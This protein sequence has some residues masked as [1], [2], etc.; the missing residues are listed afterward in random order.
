MNKIASSI[1]VWAVYFK[2]RSGLWIKILKDFKV[3]KYW[4]TLRFICIIVIFFWG[5]G[6]VTEKQLLFIIMNVWGYFNN[7]FFVFFF[8]WP[9][10][11]LRPTQSSSLGAFLNEIRKFK[12]KLE[13]SCRDLRVIYSLQIWSSYIL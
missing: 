13:A 3:L 6:D 1:M 10:S 4:K 11:I 9:G 8:F 5:G 2:P 12:P 7:S